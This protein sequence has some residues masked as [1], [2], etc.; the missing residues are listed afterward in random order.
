MPHEIDWSEQATADIESVP[1]YRRPRI[2][3]AVERLRDQAT[4]ATR[5]R[6]PLSE[7]IEGLPTATWQ[8]RVGDYRVLY[9]IEEERTVV[10]L[11]VIFKGDV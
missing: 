9:W 6:R 7:P 1:S 8:V 2:V 4:V 5:N 3:A 10:I 11:Q